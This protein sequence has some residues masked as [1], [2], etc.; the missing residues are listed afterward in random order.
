MAT[1]LT[2]MAT[3]S[4]PQSS[5]QLHHHASSWEVWEIGNAWI[6][7]WE[8]SR[9]RSPLFFRVKSGGM[10]AEG[11]SLFPQFRGSI[12]ER[13]RQNARRTV[14]RA[15]LHIKIVKNWQ[16]RS[17]FGRWGSNVTCWTGEKWE[18][19]AQQALRQQAGQER[20]KSSCGQGWKLQGCFSSPG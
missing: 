17:T 5:W 15:R 16:G 7:A 13:V 9:A 11:G 1:C 20:G 2:M 3:T 12:G 19:Q 18:F 8:H 10:V 6:Q 14:A 4:S